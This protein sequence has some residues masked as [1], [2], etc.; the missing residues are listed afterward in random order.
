[1]KGGW[2]LLEC[3]GAVEREVGGLWP[4]DIVSMCDI[5]KE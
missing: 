3:G 2:G 4:R 5:V 1:M